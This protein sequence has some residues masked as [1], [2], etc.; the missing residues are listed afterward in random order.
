MPNYNQY[1]DWDDIGRNIQ[2]II[3]RAVNSQN[4]QKL[5][6]TICQAVGRALDTGSE[7]VRKAMENAARPTA[8]SQNTS[9]NPQRPAEEKKNLP[10]LYSNANGKTT[11][12]I[13][14]TVGG[15]ILTGFSFFTLLAS[16]IFMLV[17][18][19]SMLAVPAIFL[20]AGLAGG[21]WL[22]KSGICTLGAV[23]RYKV[24]L[25]TL[26]QKTHCKLEQL[27]RS[28]GK[29]EKYVRRELQQ[30]IQDGLF[31]EGH[32]DK[33]ETC[34]ITSDETY[35]Q[36]EQSRLALEARQR[37][38]AAAAKLRQS[39]PAITPEIQEV[40][41]RGNAFLHQIRRCNDAIPGEVIS[42]KISRMEIIVQRIFE[43][44]E[45]HPEI[46]PDLKKLM[47]YYLPMTV[48]LLNAYADMDR[49]PVQGETIQASKQ[50]IEATLDTLN[51]AFEKL[52][53][54]V[55]KDTALD[56]SS[57]ISVLN[58]LL[59][60]E[61]LTEDDFSRLKKQQNPS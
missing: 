48:K 23:S 60:Q 52:L 44:A 43:R 36:Y 32:L 28:V 22:L 55:F 57:D 5:N 31:L 25:K 53:D 26:G 39:A 21:I 47:D 19:V 27:A 13:L 16:V 56:V 6:Q 3:D 59:A 42:G 14:K 15:S 9:P 49:Q 33:E 58:T 61:G 54:S 17:S 2:D 20:T 35:Q 7:A 18:G 30:M 1:Q 10:V 37:Q 45:A 29:S 51:L 38:E 12:G 34:L 50:E 46:I 24:Y 8:Q 4:Y 40:L 11:S 41:D